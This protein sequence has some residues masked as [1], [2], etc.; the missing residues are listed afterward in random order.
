ML[1][2]VKTALLNEDDLSR[3]YRLALYPQFRRTALVRAH[4]YHDPET[5]Q[6][7]PET[8]SQTVDG[9]G[10]IATL[11]QTMPIHKCPLRGPSRQTQ[12]GR[13]SAIFEGSDEPPVQTRG[14]GDGDPQLVEAGGTDRP[15]KAEKGVAL[16]ESGGQ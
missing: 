16:R 2:A 6:Q 3:W 8:E 14:V 10:N 7:I 13:L 12:A 4:Q 15:V 9:K 5:V 1:G 11:P